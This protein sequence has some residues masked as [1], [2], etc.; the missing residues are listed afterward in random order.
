MDEATYMR[1]QAARFRELAD[2]LKDP[3]ARE[4]LLDLADTC[5]HVAATIEDR[6]AAG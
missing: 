5:E 4:E 6:A 3:V 2:E 1:E